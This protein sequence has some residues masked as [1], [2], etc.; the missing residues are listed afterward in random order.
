MKIALNKLQSWEGFLLCALIFITLLNQ[1][2]LSIASAK[3]DFKSKGERNAF[4]KKVI[5]RQ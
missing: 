2:I 4:K 1:D 3:S 5:L